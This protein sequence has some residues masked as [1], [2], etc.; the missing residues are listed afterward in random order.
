MKLKLLFLLF[1]VFVFGQDID[2]SKLDSL[3]QLNKDLK[4]GLVL[5][6][7]GA[8]GL[9]HIGVLKVIEEAGIRIDYI[10]GSSMGAI[11]G[12]L[13]ASGY[14]TRQLDSIFKVTDFGA[15][16]QDNLPRQARSFYERKEAERY[17]LQ[18][19][20]DNFQVN[21]PS[22]LSKGQN[23]YNLYAQLLSHVEET[24]FSQLPIPF[25]CI[26]TNV[27]TGEQVLIE[28]GDLATSLSASGAIPTLFSPVFIDGMMLTDGGVIN[29]FPVKEV[30]AKGMDIIIGVDVQDDLRSKENLKSGFEILTQ[31]NNFRTIRAA[32]EKSLKTDLYIH[33]NIDNFSVLSFD[34]GEKIINNGELAARKKIS[35]LKLIAE[36]Q[37]KG[38]TPRQPIQ[39]NDSLAIGNI[40]IVGNNKFPRNYIRGKLKVNTF[41][42]TSFKKLNQGLNNLTATGS[43]NKINYE[44]IQNGEFKDLRL[45]IFESEQNTQLRFGI[46]YDQL[47]KT[48][49][50]AN[51]TKKSFFVTNDI[52]SLDL[53][54]GDNLRY[55]FDYYI[56]KGRY[57]SIG[58]SSRYNQFDDDVNFEFIQQNVGTENPLCWSRV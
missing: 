46:H 57:W 23:I 3:K 53:I 48:S 50:L 17:V 20:F 32:E 12:G 27:E 4:V 43:F 52:I 54:I 8:K 37:N 19:P 40:D 39:L 36:A 38:N 29:N 44:L 34:Q 47:Y 7:G 11:I 45:K 49:F 15:L 41:E 26:A 31:V 33:P 2:L 42:K 13:Y 1:P 30:R 9:A 25:F 35:P 22:G 24:D 6:G 55:N 16:I 51:L 56:D 10:G 21:L 5:S 28:E 18:L 58:V 14:T